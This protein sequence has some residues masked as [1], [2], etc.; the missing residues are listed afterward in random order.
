MKK[1]LKWVMERWVLIAGS[2]AIIIVFTSIWGFR[3]GSLTKGI[4]EPEKQYIQ[5]T[6]SGIKVARNPILLFHKIPVYAL[7]KLSVTRAGAFRAVSAGFAAAAA[8]SIFYILKR[9]YSTRIAILGTWLFITSSWLLHIGRLALP[10]AVYLL[11]LPFIAAIVWF[12]HTDRH[13]IGIILLSGM[14]GA[15][16][17]IPGFVWLFMMFLIWQRKTLWQIFKAQSIIVQAICG[18]FFLAGILPMILAAFHSPSILLRSVGYP[19]TTPSLS[20]IGRMATGIPVRLFWRGPDDPARWLG[21]LPLLDAFSAA[22]LLLGVY[23]MRYY[24]SDIRLRLLG[25]SS[26]LITLLVLVGSL[27]M[28]G[29]IPLIYILIGAGIA[30]MLQQWFAVFPRNPIARGIATALISVAV[31]LVSFHHIS[32]Y[33]IAWPQTPATRQAFNKNL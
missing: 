1:Q 33:F 23:S 24:T 14:L 10:D 11:L 9:W 28:E 26:A 3:I 7:G 32:H 27:P 2:L 15:S 18:A 4:S 30:F 31:L 12:N 16:F 20:A 29:L 22:M 5:S 21:S 6:D 8:A 25:T 13:G 19:E 17:Y